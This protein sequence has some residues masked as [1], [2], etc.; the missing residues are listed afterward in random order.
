MQTNPAQLLQLCVLNTAYWQLLPAKG[1]AGL[2]WT[3]RSCA[4]SRVY[5]LD[6]LQLH[7]FCWRSVLL[8]SMKSTMKTSLTS[9]GCLLGLRQTPIVANA[10]ALHMP[11]V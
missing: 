9:L 6:D 5:G 8:S 10:S 2:P 3:A 1:T 4:G 11:F 7:G